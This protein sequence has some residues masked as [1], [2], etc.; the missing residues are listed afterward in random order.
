[1]AELWTLGIEKRMKDLNPERRQRFVRQLLAAALDL[2][3]IEAAPPRYP[4]IRVLGRRVWRVAFSIELGVLR[5]F[6]LL[7][8]V[9]K[10][11]MNLFRVA[12][13]SVRRADPCDV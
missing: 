3:A 10:E 7:M 9:E 11:F 4:I 12:Q 2:A 1:V 8:G 6:S 13:N 5:F